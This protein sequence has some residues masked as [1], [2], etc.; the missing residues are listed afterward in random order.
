MIRLQALGALG[1]SGPGETELRSVLAQPKRLALLVYLAVASPR[2]FHRRDKLLAVFWPEL[3]EEHARGA[4]SRAVYYLRRELGDGT[5]VSRGGEELGVARDLLW[6]DAVA[7]EEALDA[8]R[9]QKAMELYRGHLLESFFVSGAAEFERWLEAERARLKQRALEAALALAGAEERRADFS[10]AV[11]W[12]RRA[13]TISPYD[14]RPALG[15]VA[16]LDRSGDHA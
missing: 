4:L 16:L 15:L 8:A 7:F 1:L 6:C 12:V 2:V 3:D 10:L 5:I 13:A 14:Q 11:Y 9:L